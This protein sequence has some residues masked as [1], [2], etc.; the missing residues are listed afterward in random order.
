MREHEQEWEPVS[1]TLEP[2][3]LKVGQVHYQAAYLVCDWEE[4]PFASLEAEMVVG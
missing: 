4:P 2:V 3:T 1:L